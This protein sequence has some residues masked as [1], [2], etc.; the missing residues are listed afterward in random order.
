MKI[1]HLNTFDNVG[2]AALIARELGTDQRQ[3]G[4]DVKY[5]VG[6]KKSTDDQV[7]QLNRSAILDRLAQLTGKDANFM[8]RGLFAKFMAN[9]VDFGAKDEVLNHPW[10]QQA[11]IVHCH[12]LHGGYLKLETLRTM[13]KAKRLVWT[14]HDAWPVM[15]H[16]AWPIISDGTNIV[17]SEIESGFYNQLPI[18][19]YP[20]MLWDNTAYL[21]AR[22]TEIY[23][24]LAVTLVVPSAWLKKQ[25][26]RSI[27]GDKPVELIHN[28]IDTTIFKRTDQQ[29]ARQELSLPL[30]KRI[31]TFV[32]ASGKNNPMKGWSFIEKAIARFA[33]QKDV[34][35]VCIGGEASDQRYNETQVRYVNYINNQAGL[36]K[37][38]SASDVFLLSSLVES[39]GLVV[40]EAM[41]CG[42]AVVAFPVGVVPEALHDQAGGY[43]ARYRDAS[44]LI[45]GVA[46]LLNRS[47]PE[48]LRQGASLRQKVEKSYSLEKMANQY[49]GL[50]RRLIDG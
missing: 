26:Q 49:Q 25:V 10:Y 46:S 44:D 30:G 28:G 16:G 43:I 29:R 35:F 21:K 1:L 18:S 17:N 24:D 40:T 33:N 34:Y 50:Y 41:S 8:Y 7:F 45:R 6:Y 36:A 14:L 23:R 3:H 38:Y 4:H 32:A 31:V 13:A 11:D 12:N 42:T 47:E 39:F 22:K 15:A 48:R 37:Y 20:A 9:D 27:L 2:G 5:L 19:T